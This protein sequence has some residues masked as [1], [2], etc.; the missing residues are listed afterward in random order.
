MLTASKMFSSVPPLFANLSHVISGDVDCSHL[1][2]KNHSVDGSPYAV[3]PQAV[4]YPKN[5]TD[6][7][8]VI[9]FAREY[10][11]PITVCGGGTAKSGG[12]LGEG[13]IID[14]TRHFNRVRHVNMLEH[15]VTVDAGVRIDELREKLAGWNMELPLLEEEHSRA[16]IGGLVATKSATPGSFYYGTIREWVEGITIIVD[17][18][19]EHHLK[20][21]VTP[22]GRLLGIYQSVFPLL[23]E[24]GPTLRAVRRE[25]SDDATGYSLWGTSIGPRQLIDQLVGSEGTL[26][27]ITSVTLRVTPIRKC[28]SSLLVPVT[29]AKLLASAISIARHHHAEKIFMFDATF[30]KLCDTFHPG[31]IPQTL[32]EAPFFLV[33]ISRHDSAET[34]HSQVRTFSK[35]L[36]TLG[37]APEEIDESC[38]AKLMN[39][40]FLHSLFRDY[41]RGTY[42]VATAGEGIIVSPDQYKEALAR[43]DESLGMAGRLFTLTGYAA[44]GHIAVTVGFDAGSPSYEYDLQEYR[45]SLFAIVRDLKG[46]LSA[47]SGDGMER[48]SALPLIFNEAA[49]DVFKKI[50]DAWD[51]LGIF[52]PSKKIAI[53]KDYLIKHAARSLE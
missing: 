45:D 48:T 9:A 28:S 46:G 31:T 5:S 35:A 14:M 1:C 30:R 53:T 51:P 23:S 38:S 10:S 8:H 37:T 50:K 16:T 4:V 7:K 11:I 29:D 36:E 39:H 34:L 49:R 2:L 13:I 6:I 3:L 47:V 27:L 17:T 33:A 32:P 26:A 12:S 41:S 42:M 20:E 22:S 25:Q 52:N 43:I 19:E 21:A 44:S 24:H 15:T 18:G 40:A